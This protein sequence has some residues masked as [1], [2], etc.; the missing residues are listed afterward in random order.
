MKRYKLLFPKMKSVNGLFA[1]Y[2][3]DQNDETYRLL[4]DAIVDLYE[5]LGKVLAK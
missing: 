5:E 3:N 4:Q 2:R 1:R